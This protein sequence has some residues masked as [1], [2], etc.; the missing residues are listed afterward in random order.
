MNEPWWVYAFT[1][2][3]VLFIW[4]VVMPGHDY[5]DDSVCYSDWRG[6]CF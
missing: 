4:I 3:F 6:A 2:L 5:P 1:A